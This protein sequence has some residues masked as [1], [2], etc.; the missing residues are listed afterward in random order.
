MIS[1]FFVWL[2]DGFHHRPWLGWSSLVIFVVGIVWL[3]LQL[4][5]SENA[6]EL[7]PSGGEANACLAQALESYR[8]KEEMAVIFSSGDTTCRL[9]PEALR[10]AAVTFDSLLH[11]DARTE[12]S[13]EAPATSEL[14]ETLPS[15]IASLIR[16][17]PLQTDSAGYAL[18]SHIAISQ[19]YTDSLLQQKAKL[20]RSPLGIGLEQTLPADPF[21]LAG[22]Q[23]RKLQSLAPP[24]GLMPYG[25]GFL[26]GGEQ[27]YIMLYAPCASFGDIA[28]NE[29]LVAA[30]E[31]AA[32]Q[33]QKAYPMV[34]VDYFG[35]AAVAVYNARQVRADTELTL[36]LALTLILLVALLCFRSFKVLPL[37]LLPALFGGGFA[38][39][40]MALVR[41][42]ISLIALGLRAAVLGIAISYAMHVL[43]DFN[44]S[45][46]VRETVKELAYPLSV[47]SFTT[48]GAFIALVFTNSRILQDF[49]LFSA[50]ALI[51]TTLFALI[52][53]P[54]MLPKHPFTSEEN[55]FYRAIVRLTGY[56]YDRKRWL[57]V[58][59]VVLA[60][61]GLFA[62]RYV[63]FDSDLSHLNYQPASLDRG[64]AMLEEATSQEAETVP[65][66]VADSNADRA[67]LRYQR[68]T[69]ELE[70]LQ[71]VGQ[72][73][74]VSSVAAFLRTKS[75]QEAQCD[76]WR[77]FWTLALQDTLKARIAQASS[78][79]GF[80][81]EAF[82]PFMEQVVSGDA[83]WPIASPLPEL[84]LWHQQTDSLALYVAYLTLRPEQKDMV[85]Q[86][87][88]HSDMALILDRSYFN[89]QWLEA[90]TDDFYFVLLVSSL[91][92]F[93]AFLV[94]YGS[95]ILTLITF[96]PMGISWLIIVLLMAL[97]GIDF[98]IVNIM[99]ATFIF[100]LG[101][102]F[103]IFV[104]DG[105][106]MR[107]S[108]GRTPLASHKV[109]IFLSALTATI[110]VGVLVFAR[111]P[112]MHSLG[113]LA[114]VG[115]GSVV[116]CAFAMPPLLFRFFV[117]K[118]L[119]RARQPY[120]VRSLFVSLH[121]WVLFLIGFFFIYCRGQRLKR[122]KLSDC[123][124][125]KRFIL[126]V[127][128]KSRFFLRHARFFHFVIEKPSD[129]E[130]QGPYIWV[131][132]HQSMVELLPLMSLAPNIV[133]MSK[134]WVWQSKFLGW[135]PRAGG[136]IHSDAPFSAI[137]EQ[138]KLRLQEGFS[139]LI[140]PEGSRSE[141]GSIGRFHKGSFEL[142]LA[143][144]VPICPVVLAGAG[145]IMPKHSLLDLAEGEIRVKVLP[146][147]DP[148]C[149]P[150]QV[151]G[152]GLAKTVKHT[153]VTEF[154]TLLR[155]YRHTGNGALLRCC[156]GCY[157]FKGPQVVQGV[158]R[159]LKAL[160]YGQMLHE[161]LP[162][163]G[164]IRLHNAGYGE[165]AIMLYLL[166]PQRQITAVCHSEAEYEIASHTPFA[167]DIIFARHI[168][169]ELFAAQASTV[170][171]LD[172][173]FGRGEKVLWQTSCLL[174]Q[175]GRNGCHELLVLLPRG[176]RLAAL[177][178]D[179]VRSEMQAQSM[180]VNRNGGVLV[181]SAKVN[182]ECAQVKK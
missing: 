140:F 181:V 34:Q 116:L 118:Q 159:H 154:E 19:A 78:A 80:K 45:G 93:L 168:D 124:R 149:L 160:Q 74:H 173:S 15:L 178:E 69:H 8:Q 95:L 88:G 90:L 79:A 107:Y 111:H 29:P 59:I 40:L 145:D 24:S 47:G 113:P 46:A 61:A 76:R 75:Q 170:E 182:S 20:L 2:Y 70:D 55:P 180:E 101:D 134:S 131:A 142:A 77:R 83:G 162:Q 37:T 157:A 165:L 156:L 82:A 72:V 137:V 133:V 11:A 179:K 147:V 92:I 138:V 54:H 32:M 73:E 153:I 161:R 122:G 151:D 42:H 53:L 136:F 86:L 38:L 6:L 150:P 91:L 36:V 106:L 128:R 12:G 123:E 172:V 135:L 98:N 100:G 97:L 39:A 126:T 109:A 87:L 96:L 84:P 144:G 64:L 49:G 85:Y 99:V 177:L 9:S 22:G 141:D 18:L 120:T 25:D 66:I 21:G 112:A 3:A 164:S 10:E 67:L 26:D 57:I 89:A 143:T 30:I 117:N 1:N 27:H 17:L 28:R 129:W 51:G 58:G 146:L 4:R 125:R 169:H 171:V 103:S 158:R 104:M 43:V 121:T 48:I 81:P 7:F 132:N 68:L 56:P 52:Y 23:L 115:M 31:K 152:R 65:I 94:S 174:G 41:G 33:L 166:S 139:V 50:L 130:S 110:G 127:H 114:L 5:F 13:L 62:G 119:V 163:S 102:D 60:F 105:L 155:A 35:G 167:R 175:L 16:Q 14:L 44:A 148:K 71:T 63:E 176:T 108:R